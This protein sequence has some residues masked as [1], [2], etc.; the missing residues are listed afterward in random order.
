MLPQDEDEAGYI[1]KLFSNQ[2]NPEQKREKSFLPA[3]KAIATCELE[4]FRGV[5]IY[6]LAMLLHKSPE[7]GMSMVTDT[8]PSKVSMVIL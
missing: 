6:M 1:A 3:F 4:G 5:A 7:S 8:L 2:L